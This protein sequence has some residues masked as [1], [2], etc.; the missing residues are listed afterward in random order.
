M[1]K[2]ALM[3]A[4]MQPYGKSVSVSITN[5]IDVAAMGQHR[6]TCIIATVSVLIYLVLTGD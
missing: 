2:I 4:L 6:F 5:L 3:I 1:S